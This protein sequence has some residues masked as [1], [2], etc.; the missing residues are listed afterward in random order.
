[1]SQPQHTEPGG[2]V[3][4][5]SHLATAVEDLSY[6]F[7]GMF[8][9]KQVEQAV[10]AAHRELAAVSTVPDFL[11]VLVTRLARERL[12]AAAQAE[13]R[14][15][16]TVPE[17]LF[18]CAHNAGRSQ[19]AAALAAHLAPREGARALGRLPADGRAQPGCRGS[20]CRTGHLP[21]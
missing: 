16:K 9:A 13:G 17:V 18:V 20:P 3:T 1:M 10:H 11:P 4:D 5:P 14:I 19:L 12:T 8:T 7:E 15:A 2:R 21:H 6:T